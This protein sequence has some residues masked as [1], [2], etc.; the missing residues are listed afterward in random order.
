MGTQ[1]SQVKYDMLS[2]Q[3]VQS[4]QDRIEVHPLIFKAINDFGL[5]S[6]IVCDNL[7]GGSSSQ[8]S[9]QAE[10][11]TR[12]S[13][14]CCCCPLSKAPTDTPPVW[15]A[16]LEFMLSKNCQ[17]QDWALQLLSFCNQKCKV[18]QTETFVRTNTRNSFLEGANALGDENSKLKFV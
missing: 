12:K 15:L 13:S 3:L 11:P 14:C 17:D 9:S 18:W 7:L 4:E 10:V 5:Q 1:Q 16:D 8:I 6:G 2:E